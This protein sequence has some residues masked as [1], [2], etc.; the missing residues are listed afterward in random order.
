MAE[1]LGWLGPAPVA[2]PPE[3]SVVFST[4]IPTPVD[5]AIQASQVDTN[6]EAPVT[7]QKALS[8]D[9]VL[10]GRNLL[11]SIATLPLMTRNPAGKRVENP[12]LKQIDPNTPN[13][14]ALAG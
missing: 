4:D 12:L 1:W 13:V 6:L 3:P 14:V 10:R 11:C 7:Q 8:S 2:E 5:D 9:V